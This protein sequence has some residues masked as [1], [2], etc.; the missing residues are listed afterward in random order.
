ME[1]PQ[2]VEFPQRNSVEI[3]HVEQKNSFRYTLKHS[4]TYFAELS[5][6]MA[7]ATSCPSFSPGLFSPTV[8]RRANL[9][10]AGCRGASAWL[11]RAGASGQAGF[12]QLLSVGR[13]AS[14][15]ANRCGR[16]KRAEVWRKWRTNV[17]ARCD[18]F[19][20]LSRRS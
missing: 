13:W 12:E 6:L 9:W 16:R 2:Q 18:F 8:R 3:S 5:R 19:L 10:H 7:V 11:R 20:A 4:G 15:S 1:V 14:Q 17:A